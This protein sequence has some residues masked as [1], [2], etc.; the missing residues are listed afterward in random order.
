MKESIDYAIKDWNWKSQTVWE[1][2]DSIPVSTLI[3][4]LEKN[5]YQTKEVEID[6]S[7]IDLTK[8]HFETDDLFDFITHYTIINNSDLS[9]P[10][11][12][13]R[14]WIILDGRHRLC[15][16]IIEGKKKL[17]GIMVIDS[18]II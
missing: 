9:F 1:W 5:Y 3:A 16:A 2:E 18:D 12:L 7:V 14:R 4:R 11:I 8:Y 6:L 17:K 15:K 13:N 10:I